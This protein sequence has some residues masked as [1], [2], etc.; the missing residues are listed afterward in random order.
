M[1]LRSVGCSVT[2]V[3]LGRL[4]DSSHSCASQFVSLLLRAVVTMQW[5]TC[6]NQSAQASL[7]CDAGGTVEGPAATADLEAQS[8]GGAEIATTTSAC[9]GH[10]AAP[11]LGALLS[12]AAM[13]A[14]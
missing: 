4:H 3:L 11:A 6:Y 12:V 8:P 5:C 9:T 10:A 13:L 7:S 1:L 14:G 2:V